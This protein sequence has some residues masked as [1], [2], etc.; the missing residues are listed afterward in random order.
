MSYPI[1]RNAPLVSVIIPAYNAEATIEQALNSVLAQTYT[2]FEILVVDDGSHDRTG[3]ILESFSAKDSRVVSIKQENSGVAAARNLAIEKSTGDYVAPL[4]AD[5]VW[6]PQKLQK[7]VHCLLSTGPSV[8]LVYAW[9]VR[10]DEDDKILGSIDVQANEDFNS[11]E[12]NVLPALVYSNFLSCASVPLIRRTCFERIGV[13][14][15]SLKARDAQGCEDWDIYLRIA[16]QYEFRV[17]R[18]F[19]VGYRQTRTRMSTNVKAMSRSY[20]LVMADSRAR[21]PGISDCLYRR[22][23]SNFGRYLSGISAAHGDYASA[24]KFA[25]KAMRSDP[26]QVVQPRFPTYLIKLLLKWVLSPIVKRMGRDPPTWFR[27]AKRKLAYTR[28]DVPADPVIHFSNIQA[29]IHHARVDPVKRYGSIEWRRWLEIL[30]M[31][32]PQTDEVS[33][34]GG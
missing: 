28:K 5:D 23:S 20:D 9:V 34:K 7:Q 1:T 19:M 31:C 32:Q 21:Q 30:A 3:Q 14:S 2:N 26:P 4:D 16:E 17:V 13:Y 24:L 25:L 22:S 12:G 6:H 11:V 33:R 10:I 29:Q 18:G 27:E 15:T 8:G